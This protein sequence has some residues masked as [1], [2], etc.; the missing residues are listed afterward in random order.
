ML[1][2]LKIA[3]ATVFFLGAI[4]AYKAQA[5]DVMILNES[6]NAI[7]TGRVTGVGNGLFT[8]DHNGLEVVVSTNDLELARGNLQALLDEGVY[9]TV[10]GSLEDGDVLEARRVIRSEEPVIVDDGVILEEST[11]VVTPSPLNP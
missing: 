8:M 4:M 7:I 3:I 10:E 11:D 6:S 2:A 1:S 9:V 5:D